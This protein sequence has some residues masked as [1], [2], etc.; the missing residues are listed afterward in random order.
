MPQASIFI[1]ED[2]RIVSEDIRQVLEGQGYSVAGIARSGESVLEILKKVH[3]DL[4][5]MDIHLAGEMDGIDTAEQIR[6]RY[7]IPVIFLTAH[8]DESILARA[9]VTEPVRLCP[10]TI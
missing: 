2:E 1:V 4:V 8:E 9:K 10:Q 5:L 6:T 7:H 3:P